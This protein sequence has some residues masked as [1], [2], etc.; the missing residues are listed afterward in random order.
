M[1][2]TVSNE[3][4]TALFMLACENGKKDEYKNALELVNSAFLEMREYVMFL[5][6]KSIPLSERLDA[7]EGA[8]SGKI[9]EEVL[10]YLMLLCEKG[11]IV[12]FSDSVNEYNKL[13]DASNH[14]TNVKVTSATTLSETEKEKLKAKL[15]V[16]CK[17]EVSIE[18]ET[19]ETLLGG[20]TLEMDGKVL[21][22]SIK[23]RMR[24]IK[25]VISK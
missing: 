1:M 6:S 19:D 22:G 14:V 2:Q 20:I 12:S 13:F 25:D 8:F 15:Q 17:S 10:S 7:L 11:R 21:D 24:D 3:Y 9:P 18:Y 16:M 23:S 5:A 4:A